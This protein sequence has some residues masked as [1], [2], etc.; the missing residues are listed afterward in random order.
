MQIDI[1]VGKPVTGENLIG[2]DK[3]IQLIHQL[4]IQGQSIVLVAP[5]RFGKTT[6]LLEV[7][8]QLKM[9]GYYTASIDMFTI[10]SLE[11]MAEQITEKVLTNKKSAWSIHK[12]KENLIELMR[13]VEFRQEIE[14]FEYMLGFGQKE[15]DPWDL[16][17]KSIDFINEFSAKNNHKI[18]CS[19]D[20][21]GDINKLDGQEI[22]KLFR[23]KI[24]LQ[25]NSSFLFAGSYASVMSNLFV[26]KDAPFYRF[27]RVI[28]VGFID[29][30]SFLKYYKKTLMKAEISIPEDFLLSILNFTK[31]H[32]YYSQLALQQLITLNALNRKEIF[33]DTQ[34]FIEYLF[35]IEKDYIEK[36][37]EDLSKSRDQIQVLL[38]IVK[39]EKSLYSY[40][41]SRKI[42]IPRTLKKLFGNGTLLQTG[43]NYILSDPLLEHFIKERVLL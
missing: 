14:G 32:P 16:L 10:T 3:E 13:N 17:S 23:S 19:L 26:S 33:R 20:E 24:Q 12:I 18:I 34:E 9:E 21:F 43:K 6:I 28:N 40:L 39:Q 5:R 38:A 1:Q 11:G 2:R 27:A 15:K 41:D 25:Q 7:I 35:F 42:N 30:S 29:T 31:G 37:W 4:L 36:L 8:N 22:I